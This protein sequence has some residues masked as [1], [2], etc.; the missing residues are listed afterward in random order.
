M[1][2]QVRAP[3]IIGHLSVIHRQ[4]ALAMKGRWLGPMP[5]EEFLQEFLEAFNE[6]YRLD[7]ID[8]GGEKKMLRLLIDQYPSWH[9]FRP[10]QATPLFNVV[11]SL[12]KLFKSRYSSPPNDTDHGYLESSDQ[13]I[14]IIEE[15]LQNRK[16]HWPTDDGTVKLPIQQDPVKFYATPRQESITTSQHIVDPID[17][18]KSKGLPTQVKRSAS[19]SSQR[20]STKRRRRASSSGD[21]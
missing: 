21:D 4:L 5:I 1:D 18:D 16:N 11:Q 13:L 6:S 3:T 9:G 20:P 7:G 2:T 12:S 14:K 17:W 8:C 10:K 19:Q 15:V